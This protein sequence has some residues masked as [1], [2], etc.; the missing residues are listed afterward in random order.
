MGVYIGI[1]WGSDAHAVC[2]MTEDD[3]VVAQRKLPNTGQFMALLRAMVGD[4][5]NAQVAIERS[6]LLIVDA[7]L[8]EGVAVFTLNPKQTDR[9]R[10]RF[11]PS[12]AKDDRR[13]ALVLASALRTDK[14]A[15]RRVALLPDAHASLQAVE[16]A[17]GEVDGTARVMSNRLWHVLARY[18]PV[19]L[20]VGGEAATDQAWLWALLL[21]WSTPAKAAEADLGALQTLLKTHRIRRITAEQLHEAL[22][23]PRLQAPPAVERACSA[24]AHRLIEQL[25]LLR[26]QKKALEAE[27]K[28]LL[29]A[30]RSVRRD[31]GKPNDIE[32]LESLP[33]VGPKVLATLLGEAGD[34]ITSRDLRALRTKSGVAPVTTQTGKQKL[35]RPFMR[36][37]RD[38]RLANAMFHMVRVGAQRDPR[39]EQMLAA[40]R[41]RGQSMG[42]AM[43]GIA[44][45]YLDLLMSVLRSRELYDPR[46]R[47]PLLPGAPASKAA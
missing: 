47:Q 30:L 42:R 1:D 18:F 20:S 7:L 28:Q 44:D 21:S 14:K 37:A 13:D 5:V 11:S 6:D 17:I 26:T 46:R 23:A 27:R 41:A 16:R 31:D 9:F 33:G 10:D 2:V 12:G 43:R 40:A 32:L 34:A 39:L 3:R 15:F 36:R 24:E 8:A 4:L 19:L 29:D 25:E 35:G 22:G 38:E 45:R